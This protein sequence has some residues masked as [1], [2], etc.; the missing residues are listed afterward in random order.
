MD[1]FENHTVTCDQP[2]VPML[3]RKAHSLLKVLAS[4][5]GEAGESSGGWFLPSFLTWLSTEAQEFVQLRIGEIRGRGDAGGSSKSKVSGVDY[6]HDR[7]VPDDCWS[8][9]AR[10][11]RAFLPSHAIR[12]AASVYYLPKSDLWAWQG[13]V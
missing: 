2:L 10:G 11:Q 9:A 13:R 7:T 3:D 1:Q 4:R 6:M 12:L 5:K 8:L